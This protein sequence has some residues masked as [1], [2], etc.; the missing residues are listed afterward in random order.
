MCPDVQSVRFEHQIAGHRRYLWEV[1]RARSWRRRRPALNRPRSTRLRGADDAR[2]RN[3]ILKTLFLRSTLRLTEPWALFLASMLVISL[4]VLDYATGHHFTLSAFYLMP[5]LWACAVGGRPAGLSFAVLSAAIWLVADLATSHVYPHPAIPYWNAATLLV[6][7]V[8]VVH[9][10]AAV[11]SSNKHLEVTVQQ[12]TAALQAEIAER[13]RLEAAKLQADRL[14]MVGTIAAQVA[15]E[16]R[17]PLGSITLN[18]DLIA[19][20]IEGLA[21]SSQR[22]AQEGRT[23]VSEMREEV[24]RIQDVIE[25]YLRFARM[26]KPQ[27]K[28][29]KLNQLLEQKLAFMEP[30]FKKAGVRLQTEFDSKLRCINADAEQLWQAVLNLLQNSLEATLAGGAVTV[31]T[32]R[33]NGELLLAVSDNGKGMTADQL[34]QVFA[35]FFTTKPL[36]TGLG[37]PLTQRIVHEHGGRIECQS[38]VGKG[39]TLTIHLPVI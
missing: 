24:R 23:L 14:A 8:V 29:V 21:V 10:M 16:V 19:K 18:L 12:R 3:K 26:P 4:G 28:P 20:E 38:A 30:V 22:S 31:R 6:L 39:T 35:P 17:N 5:I 36:G 25:D 37:L 7:F 33:E 15:H 34:N 1:R 27:R 11:L 2:P 32:I 9:L 13:E